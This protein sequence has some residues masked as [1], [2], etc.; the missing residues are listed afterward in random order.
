LQYVYVRDEFRGNRIGRLMVEQ[1]VAKARDVG[2]K[3]MWL[4][5]TT[6]MK[7]ARALYVSIGFRPRGPY[8]EERF[9][10][11]EL[12]AVETRFSIPNGAG[13][14]C[15]ACWAADGFEQNRRP[16]PATTIGSQEK[17]A[18]RPIDSDSL[19]G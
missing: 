13:E 5:T 16:P 14:A 3:V 4:E 2:Y 12:V 15:D 6:F 10:Q 1:L 11:G 8:Y 17:R 7:E 18:W 19:P 9:V